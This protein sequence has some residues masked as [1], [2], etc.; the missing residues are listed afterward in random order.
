MVNKKHVYGRIYCITNLVNGKQYIGKTKH[1]LDRRWEKHCKDGLR[2]GRNRSYLHNAIA[3]HGVDKFVCKQVA[4]AFSEKTLNEAECR[5]I[6]TLRTLAPNG[7]NLRS[8]GD[9]GILHPTT[10]AKMSASGKVVWADKE[11]RAK[12]TRLRRD[13][14]LDSAYRTKIKSLRSTKDYRAKLSK[15]QK[16]L[17]VDPERRAK[18]S[19]EMKVRWSNLSSRA[20]SEKQSHASKTRWAKSDAS[21]K[22]SK[23]LKAWWASPAGR[24]KMMLSRSSPEF[25]AKISKSV[26]ARVIDPAYLKRMG[27]AIKAGWATSEHRAWR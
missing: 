22:Q 3:K 14:W 8:G 19:R 1:L 16:A 20:I 17:W 21:S 26:R 12:M 13:V 2:A 4:V 23:A 18:M 24:A 6:A 5:W 27:A 11:Y 10:C 7:Y 9:G 25:R 15:A